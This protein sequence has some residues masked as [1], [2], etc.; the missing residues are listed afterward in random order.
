MRTHYSVKTCIERTMSAWVIVLSLLGSLSAQSSEAP[1]AVS[2]DTKLPFFGD[3]HIHT[4]YSFDSYLSNQ[5]NDPDGAYEY[6]K[7]RVI[8]LPNAYGD[9]TVSAQIDR[10]IDFAAVTD[11]GQFLGEVALCDSHWSQAAWWAPVCLM[12]RAQNLWIQLYA[13]SLW[14]VSGGMEGKAPERGMVCAL[15]DCEASA[16]S[17]WGDIQAA[18]ERHYDR[19][20]DCSFTTFVGYE[21]TQG[22]EMANLH[23]NVIFRNEAVT[24]RPISVFET[25]SSVPELW[26]QL[27]TQCLDA[28]GQCDVMAIPHNPNLGGGLMFPDPASE[29]EAIDRLEIEPLVELVQHKGASECRFDRLAGVGIDTEDELCAFEQ[30]PSDNLAMLGSVNGKMWSDR[31]L[32]VDVTNFHRRNM[33]R[34]VLKDGLALEQASG[35]NPFKQGFIGS[36]DTHTATSGGAMEKNYVGHLG[37]RDATFRNLQDH[38]VSNPGGLA[39][40]WAEENRRDAIFNAMRGR[41]TY[42]TSGTR[43]IVRFFAGDYETDLC[44]DP[45][46]LEKAYASGVPM[47]GILIRTP[48]DSAPRFFISAQRDHGTELHP[49]NPLER[50]QII[51]GWVRADGTTHERVVDV[52]GSETEGL[53]VDMNSCAATAAGQA[54]LCSVWEDPD[55]SEGESAFYYARILETP[56][57]RWSTLQCQA[58]NVN[59]FSESCSTQADVANELANA[60]GNSGDLY[61]I[62]C[63]NPERDPFY[64]PT[65]RERAWTS[66]IWLSKTR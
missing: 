61:G 36:T 11:H 25:E 28:D 51:K 13:A 5:K 55:Y 14:T 63:T 39:V 48:D 4:R 2:S 64:S 65:I 60:Q 21:Y 40:V 43:P 56:S 62:C 24:A 10:P 57:C 6:A 46:A 66:P 12:S 33:M 19:S 45:Q 17:V 22:Q 16:L 1:C 44:D 54:S 27:R 15:G 35:V 26:R 8:T 20:E 38:F 7:G 23:R 3:L 58:A 34:N 53:G 37:S 50:I 41:E 59:P 31:G 49:A 32:P 18:A 29:Q 47:G 30:I 52:L 9:Q 42:A